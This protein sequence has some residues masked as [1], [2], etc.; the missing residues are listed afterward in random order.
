M[1]H[2]SLCQ[3]LL[4]LREELCRKLSIPADQVE[5]SMGM[6][7]DFQH[8]V[9][10]LPGALRASSSGPKAPSKN[11]FLLQKSL[12]VALGAQECWLSPILASPAASCL[13]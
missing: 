6:S 3:V 9:S 8:A 2:S 7:M 13:K 1:S 12:V 4:S 11:V 10:V 5:L